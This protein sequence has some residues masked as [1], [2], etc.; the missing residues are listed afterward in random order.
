MLGGYSFT[1]YH[2]RAS[3]KDHKRAVT[4]AALVVRD[5]RDPDARAAVDRATILGDAVTLCRDLVNTPG[6]RPAPRR[7]RR[8]AVEACAEVGCDVEVSDEVALAEGGYGGIIGVG[9]GAAQPAAAGADR[10]V[11]RR[12]RARRR[13]TWSA[14]ASRSTP[15]ACRSSR[16]P[17]WSG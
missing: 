4:S 14:R 16:R 10:L 1:T 7:S 5:P 15:A 2:T 9:Q 8:A 13:S 3:S 17:R 12:S 11:R 6:R